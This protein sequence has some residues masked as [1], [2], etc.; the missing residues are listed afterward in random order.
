MYQED[1]H[2]TQ[3][4]KGWNTGADLSAGIP[5][6]APKAVVKAVRSTLKVRLIAWDPQT[7][8]ARWSVE[9]ENAWNGGVLSTAG[10]LVFQG[11]LNGEFTAYN[12]AT[13]E[14]LWTYN[15]QS[16]GAS[17]PGTFSIDGEQY[18]TITTGWGSAF[19]LTTGLAYQGRA[20]ATVGKVVT[21][22]LNGKGSIAPPNIPSIEKIAKADA[23]GDE[24]AV[25]RGNNKYSTTCLVCHGALAISSGVLPDLRWSAIT[26]N[27]D[28][29][30]GVVLDGALSSNGMVS[31]KHALNED[32]AE[33]IR[34][35]VLSQ[36]HT[37]MAERAA[38]AAN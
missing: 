2:F 30:R 31:F 23:F 37:D 22:K 33:D 25:A 5:P 20:S 19:A 27:A 8:S 10:N 26:G 3:N 17:G 38:E 32:D 29:W 4:E 14:S 24:A 34:A 12:A 18:V 36:A 9:H 21:F 13:G 7:Q 28:A 16:G 15:I 6:I 11:K 1:P 35:Y